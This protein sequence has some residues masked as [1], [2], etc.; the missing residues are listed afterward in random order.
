MEPRQLPFRRQASGISTPVH[1]ILAANDAIT[2]AAAAREALIP[3]TH[4]DIFEVPQT[5]FE[6]F[7]DHLQETIDVTTRW[8]TTDFQ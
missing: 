6:L 1:A 5:H 7:V 4:L 3:I 8:F 2:P